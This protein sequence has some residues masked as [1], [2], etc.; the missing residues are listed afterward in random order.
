MADK[1]IWKSKTCIGLV[2]ALLLVIVAPRLGLTLPAEY[3][4][5]IWAALVA[6]IV[7]GLRDAKGGLSIPGVGNSSTPTGDSDG[8]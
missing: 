6:F 8:K 3:S 5:D 2:L 4:T 7:F 1:A